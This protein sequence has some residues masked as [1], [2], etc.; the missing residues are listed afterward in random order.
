MPRSPGCPHPK[1]EQP[2][3]AVQGGATY[4]SAE[5]LPDQRGGHLLH[6]E[7]VHAAG[8]APEAAAPLGPGPWLRW[9]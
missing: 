3:K 1:L 2:P 6:E 7:A 4:L 5:E 9:G 8:S